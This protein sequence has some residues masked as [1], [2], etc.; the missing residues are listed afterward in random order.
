MATAFLSPS[1]LEVYTHNPL[2][3]YCPKMDYELVTDLVKLAAKR[4]PL[5]YTISVF[6]VEADIMEICGGDENY[7]RDDEPDNEV[8]REYAIRNKCTSQSM[9][10]FGPKTVERGLDDYLG[11]LKNLRT[12]AGNVSILDPSILK[13]LGRLQCL[14][15]MIIYDEWHAHGSLLR[16][17]SKLPAAAFPALREISLRLLPSSYTPRIWKITQLVRRLIRV[18]ILFHG[19]KERPNQG[20]NPFSE[21]PVDLV[22][23]IRTLCARSPSLQGFTFGLDTVHGGQGRQYSKSI[24]PTA[25]VRSLASLPLQKL[26]L[27]SVR[28]QSSLKLAKP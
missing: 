24:V 17:Y 2:S 23:F 15:H 26:D 4:C 6:P 20:H 19:D 9:V 7:T 8:E 13:S 16:S 28:L 18:T 1:L 14:K 11:L 25:T 10:D 5:L 22:D 27:R 12:I 3:L 21:G